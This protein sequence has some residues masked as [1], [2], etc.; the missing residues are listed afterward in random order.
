MSAVKEKS[1][2]RR[3]WI[4]LLIFASVMAVGQKSEWQHGVIV[5]VMKHAEPQAADSQ[6]SNYDI[7]VRVGDYVYVVL[8]TVP[9]NSSTVEYRVGS[10]VVVLVGDS[11]LTINDVQG[12]PHRG[13]ILSRKEITERKEQ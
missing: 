9:K 7:T 10:D 12:I 2:M 8:Y 5:A 11:T 1:S 6:T 13:R 3:H 4:A